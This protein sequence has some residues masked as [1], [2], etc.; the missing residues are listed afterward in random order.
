MVGTT[1][2]SRGQN[3]EA[4]EVTQAER[5]YLLRVVAHALP[6]VNLQDVKIVHEFSGLRVL[7]SGHSG[8][9]NPTGKARETRLVHSL[10]AK[11]YLAIYGGKLTSYRAT[12]QKVLAIL[13][14]WLPATHK[15][16]TATETLPLG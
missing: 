14:P 16:P 6:A 12:A 11:P 5:D 7:P 13:K 2:L 10:G 1:E 8:A 9:N 15:V 4:N 3:A